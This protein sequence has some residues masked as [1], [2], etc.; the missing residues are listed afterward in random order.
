VVGSEFL[1][2]DGEGSFVGGAGAW[3]VTKGT[4]HDTQIV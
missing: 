1:F 2:S 3:Q 4:Q